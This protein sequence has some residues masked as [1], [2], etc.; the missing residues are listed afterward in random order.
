MI[1][2]KQNVGVRAPV[3]LLNSA[4]LPVTGVTA[5]AVSATVFYSDG[6]S[7]SLTP[8][9]NWFETAQGGYQLLFTPTVLGPIQLVVTAA[10]ANPFVGGFDCVSALIGDLSASVAGATTA[11]NAA[12]AAAVAALNAQTG[13]WTLDPVLNQL[14]IFA[15][16]NVTVI[17]RF[18]CFDSGGLPSVT[19]VFQRVRI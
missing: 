3:R 4:G 12:Q 19:N 1:Q 18:N 9:G 14:T 13:G 17:A 2:L 8:A 7:S 10:G 16:D 11:A 5:G 15:P 6:T